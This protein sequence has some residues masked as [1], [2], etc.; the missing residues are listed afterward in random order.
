M[1]KV[2]FFDRESR[3][4][5]EEQ[6]YGKFFLEFLYSS[7]FIGKLI[8]FFYCKSKFF[9][10]LYGAV[11]SLPI[12]KSKVVPFIKKF[13]VNSSEFE[14]TEFSSFNDFFIRKLKP[15][16]RPLASSALVMPCDGRYR[17]FR[18][19]DEIEVKGQKFNLGALVGKPC[20]GDLLM[21]RLAPVDYHRFHFPCHCKAKDFELK[22]G[23]LESVNPIALLPRLK[24]LWEN[25]RV[26]T[27]LE[28]EFG[29]IY[30][31]EVGATNVGSI[32]QTYTPGERKKG[33]EKGY[34]SFGGSAVLM[35]FEKGRVDF[36]KDL[37]ENENREI[38]A[39]MGTPLS[40]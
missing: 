23:V 13:N 19:A 33:D 17:L 7:G 4:L 27:E 15:E 2:I 6:I 14:K 28:T 35:L 26:V 3:S 10:W 9:S 20:S 18:N 1:N 8:R 12:T 29:S 38:Y 36:A 21:A 31:I 5:R 39:K 32:T 25:K 30:Y 16:A 40:L 37:L 24:T 22:N 11:Q 34:F